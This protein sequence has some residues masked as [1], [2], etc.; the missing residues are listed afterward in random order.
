MRPRDLAPD[1]PYLRA[2]DLLLAPVNVCDLLAAVEV[3]SLRVIDAFDFD[4]GCAGVGVALSPLVREVLALRRLLVSS[5]PHACD[6]WCH[7]GVV[8][9]WW[10]WCVGE[11]CLDVEP[12][13]CSC[14]L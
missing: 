3:C 7:D 9:P 5:L 2:P 4:E 10:W 13:T 11:T 6:S 14:L 8:S 1:D 12:V